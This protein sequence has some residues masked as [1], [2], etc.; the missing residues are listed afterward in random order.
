MAATTEPARNTTQAVHGD[1]P[2]GWPTATSQVRWATSSSAVGA[3]G[4]GGTS[5]SASTLVPSEIRTRAP[6]TITSRSSVRKTSENSPTV[7]MPV[8]DA[9]RWCTVRRSLPAG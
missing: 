6:G 1:G 4:A 3:S 5:V 7:T 9:L 2:T 8:R